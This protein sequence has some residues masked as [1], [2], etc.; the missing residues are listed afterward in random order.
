MPASVGIVGLVL[1]VVLPVVA[2]ALVLA[3]KLGM[4]S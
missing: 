3:R 4:F 1:V 2:L